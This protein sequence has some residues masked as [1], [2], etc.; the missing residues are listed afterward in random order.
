LLER[1]FAG[2]AKTAALNS[3]APQ[4]GQNKAPERCDFVFP[5]FFKSHEAGFG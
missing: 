3:I 1:W 4:L 2:I 5:E